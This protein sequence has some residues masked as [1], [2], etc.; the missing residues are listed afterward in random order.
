MNVKKVQI[1]HCKFHPGKVSHV[2]CKSCGVPICDDCKIVTDIGVFCSEACYEK[3]KSFMERVPVVH[4]KKSSSFMKII[5]RFVI[6]VVLLAVIAAILD[7]LDVV[8]VPV[9]HDIL[10]SLGF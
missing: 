1:E 8:E 4:H 5:G 6:I 9:I 3:T 2:R 7:A 10:D